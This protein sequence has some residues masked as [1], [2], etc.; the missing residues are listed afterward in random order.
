VRP[1]SSAILPSR[2]MTQSAADRLEPLRRRL[3]VQQRCLLLE[4]QV[5]RTRDA[6]KAQA[7]AAGLPPHASE[8][9]RPASPKPD[10]YSRQW[11]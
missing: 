11:R 4:I 3:E 7:E 2:P 5:R 8:S 10:W 9:E 6:Q 1:I